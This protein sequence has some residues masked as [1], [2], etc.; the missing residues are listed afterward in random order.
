MAIGIMPAMSAKVVIRIG[1]RRTRP[2][3]MMAWRRDMPCSSDHFAKSTSRIAF[4]ATMPISRMTPIMLMML[5]RRARDEQR[6]HDADERERQ[7]Q[8]DRERLEER[9]ELDDEHEVHQQDREP[10]RGEDLTE[11]LG[12]VLALAAG[13]DPVARRQLHARVEPGAD[14]AEHLVERAGLAYSPESR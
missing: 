3:S 14:V 11:H 8:H 9:T 2:A 1:R 5:M 12:L 7:R 4:F 6:Q 13:L 10:E